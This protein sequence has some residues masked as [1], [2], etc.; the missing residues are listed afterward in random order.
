MS[1][2]DLFSLKGK[3]ALITGGAGYFGQQFVRG[4]VDCGAD[5]IIVE[6]PGTEWDGCP[7]KRVAWYETDLYDRE[8]TAVLYDR[9]LGVYQVDILI[10]NAFEFSPRTGFVKDFALD[11]DV[12]GQTTYEQMFYSFESGI[13]WAFQATQKFGPAMKTRGQGSIINIASPYG[14]I[15]PSPLTYQGFSHTPNPPGYGV[16]KAGLL[17][18][19]RYSA[20]WLAP[21]RVNALLPGAIPNLKED[22]ERAGKSYHDEFLDRLAERMILGRFGKVQELVG[23][24]IF[25]ASDASSYVTAHSLHVD[26]GWTQI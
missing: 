19:T 5:V 13:W 10:N 11:G 1:F 3:T 18:L 4:L 15:A 2:A 26:G 24:L 22:P 20:S 7:P 23:P 17:Q 6:K 25:L 16:A 14:V 12:F 21:V 9:I 8:R